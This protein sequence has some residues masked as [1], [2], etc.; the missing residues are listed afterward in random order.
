MRT[1]LGFGFLACL[2]VSLAAQAD[3]V[4]ARVRAVYYQ[5]AGGVLLEPSLLRRPG[6]A[7]WVDVELADRSRALVQLPAG[8]EARI[9]DVVAVQLATPKSIATAEPMRVSRVTGIRAPDTQLATPA[10]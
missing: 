7:R 8:M 3:E 6:G 5:A 10:R 4:T 2:L 1:A 9:G